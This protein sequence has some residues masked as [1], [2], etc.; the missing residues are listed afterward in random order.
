MPY[1]EHR[2]HTGVRAR[3]QSFRYALNGLRYMLESQ[4]NA[5]IHAFFTLAVL[6]VAVFAGLSR[7]EWSLLILAVVTVWTA[8]ALNTAFEALADVASPEFHPL[9]ERAKDV[10]AG[11]V[12]IAAV[13]AAA[14]GLVVIGPALVE[15][16]SG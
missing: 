3:I 5:W 7:V 8:E 13:G 16:F 15:R 11:A 2:R 10:A 4:R 14:I 12:L 6:G 9:V 1:L